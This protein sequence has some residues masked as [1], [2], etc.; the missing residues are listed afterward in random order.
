MTDLPPLVVLAQA[1]AAE[2]GM[3]LSREGT[4]PSCCLPGV[5]RFLAVL[6]AG[7]AGGLIGE[8]GTGVGVGAAW[9]ASAM[10]AGCRLV[11]VELDPVRVAAAQ[12]VF[13][14]QDR[15]EVIH[16]DSYDELARRAPFDLV[17]VDGG[18]SDRVVELLRIGGR[19]VFDD[20]TPVEALPADSPYRENDPK[21]EFFFTDSRLVATEVVLPDLQNSLL[22]GTRVR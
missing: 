17:F 16:G 3:P 1:A 5:G 13:A 21:R 8:M 10:P 15:V 22:V 20:V 9:M 12:R 11:T 4:G 19:L 6:A 18:P 14:D 7:C 2:L